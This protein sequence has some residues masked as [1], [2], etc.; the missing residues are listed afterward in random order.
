M[1]TKIEWTKRIDFILTDEQK[2]MIADLY[3]GGEIINYSVYQRSDNRLTIYMQ[4]SV[5]GRKQKSLPKVLLEAKIGRLLTSTETCDHIDN[6]SLNNDL[7]NLQVLSRRDNILKAY[8]NGSFDIE[9]LTAFSKTEEGRK[10]SS[11][12]MRKLNESSDERAPTFSDEQVKLLRNQYDAKEIDVQTICT[13][14]NVTRR[15]VENML[16]GDTYSHIKPYAN[17]QPNKITIEM[18]EETKR[19][20]KEGKSLRSI[21]KAFGVH[22]SGLT[23]RLKSH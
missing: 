5:I 15:A 19:L 17:W 18:V 13:Q 8:H 23:Y 20:L 22:P 4:F 7:D 9:K 10:A 16:K 6:N 21:A 1:G 3:Q 14:Y 11:E 2:S 12:R